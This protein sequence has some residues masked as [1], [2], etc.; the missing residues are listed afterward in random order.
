MTA[1]TT[2]MKEVVAAPTTAAEKR[3]FLYKSDTARTR[4]VRRAC[5]R[6]TTANIDCVL[7]RTNWAGGSGLRTTGGGALRACLEEGGGGRERQG[8]VGGSDSR[9][10]KAME[11]NGTWIT[12]D[13]RSVPP[14]AQVLPSFLVC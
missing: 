2:G 8:E 11:D 6:K 7:R 13:E 10:Y 12:V 4:C 9:E 1:S 3:G 5:V 14:G